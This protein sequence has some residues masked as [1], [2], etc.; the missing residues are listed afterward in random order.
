[1][2]ELLY[3]SDPAGKPKSLYVKKY[4]KEKEGKNAAGRRK[5]RRQRRKGKEK[6][7]GKERKMK[8]KDKGCMMRRWTKRKQRGC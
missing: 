5:G 4:L 3:V 2:F 1:M 8:W 7:E 6:K